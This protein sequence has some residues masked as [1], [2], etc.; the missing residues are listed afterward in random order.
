MKEIIVKDWNHLIDNIAKITY[1][2]GRK[3]WYRGQADIRWKLLPTVKRKPYDKDGYEQ[4]LTTD[5]YIETKRRMARVPKDLSGWL[6]LMQHY[7]LP[8]RLLDWSESPLVALYFATS[9]WDKYSEHDA[10]IW[11]LNPEKLN[12][13]QGYNKSL[14]PM[15]YEIVMDFI[16]G[17][18]R[19]CE[20]KNSVIACC[21]VENDLRMYVQQSNFTVHD[22]FIAL[23]D[24]VHSDEFLVKLRISKELKRN[25]YEQLNLLGIKENTIYPDMEHI[26]HELRE[27][28]SL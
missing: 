4:F 17:A 20:S 10:V 19:F 28:F 21:N 24:L 25:I 16:E 18:F 6:S 9:N 26:A 15:D 27:E 22:S 12:Y 13:M 7:G 2:E 23:E 11:V 8:T 1:A 3:M 5:F 14:F